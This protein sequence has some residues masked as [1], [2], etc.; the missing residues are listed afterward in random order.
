MVD[1][2]S[3]KNEKDGFSGFWVLECMSDI[4]F[5]MAEVKALLGLKAIT[6]DIA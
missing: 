5:S 6:P 4:A 3:K 2:N 1:D